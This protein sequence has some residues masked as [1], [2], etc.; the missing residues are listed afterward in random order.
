M[1]DSTKPAAPAW[2]R[3]LLF[4]IAGSACGEMVSVL[5]DAEVLVYKALTAH[6]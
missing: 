6:F 2:C 5:F 1:R 3:R 4:F